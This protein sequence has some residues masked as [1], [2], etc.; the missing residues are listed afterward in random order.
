MGKMRYGVG[1]AVVDELD[2]LDELEEEVLVSP[3]SGPPI[4]GVGR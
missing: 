1:V 3:H 4:E 2:E